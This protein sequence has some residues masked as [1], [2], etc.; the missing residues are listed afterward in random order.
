[1]ADSFFASVRLL[2]QLFSEKMKRPVR[3]RRRSP[4]QIDAGEA[5][6]DEYKEVIVDPVFHSASL[7]LEDCLMLR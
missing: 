2:T 1:M 4:N 5:G 6:Q 3:K 7:S